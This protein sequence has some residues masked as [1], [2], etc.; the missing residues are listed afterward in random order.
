MDEMNQ[1]LKRI[2][3][4]LGIMLELKGIAIDSCLGELMIP[5]EMKRQVHIK[6]QVLQYRVNDFSLNS[7]DRQPH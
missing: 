1:T 2:E 3:A 4:M 5:E 7:N 6:R